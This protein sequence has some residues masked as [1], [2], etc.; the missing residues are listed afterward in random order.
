MTVELAG[1]VALLFV[2]TALGVS[3]GLALIASS[4]VGITLLIG[5]GNLTALT[6][7][8]VMNAVT[9]YATLSAVLLI[10][11]GA[12]LVHTGTV[13]SLPPRGAGLRGDPDR[14]TYFAGGAFG[15][16]L[17]ASAALILVAVTFELSIVRLAAA[18]LLPGLAL[19]ALYLAIFG[20]SRL[21]RPAPLELEA[22]PASD[23]GKVLAIVFRCLVPVLGA[24]AF[25]APIQ[26]GILTPTEAAALAAV[27]GL[28]FVLVLSLVSKRA[29]GGAW[30]GFSAGISAAAVFLLILVGLTLFASVLSLAGAAR[31]AAEAVA[32][33][34][35]DGRVLLGL[36]AVL[37]LIV[38]IVLGPLAGVGVTG[39]AAFALLTAAGVDPLA[40]GVVL[41]L[42]AEAIRVGPRL[43]RGGFL[44]RAGEPGSWPYFL[45]AVAAIAGYILL[46]DAL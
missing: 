39:A 15:V 38:G 13:L 19:S 33:F 34:T 8:T 18:A 25:L 11:L 16:P 44:R 20:L 40:M 26:A 1:V 17:P 37:A 21:I 43:W 2:L 12:L 29:R 32:P 23:G 7:A 46:A 5:V 22:A 9:A 35:L 10:G 41:F 42:A 4:M 14:A 27:V 30:P 3:A 31:L 6:G 28:I 36:T 45:A 24:L